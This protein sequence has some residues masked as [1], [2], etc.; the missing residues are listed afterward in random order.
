MY[1]LRTAPCFL[2]ERLEVYD[3]TLPSIVS[4]VTNTLLHK[5]D[6]AWLQ[7]TLPV[8]L[9]SLGAQSAMQVAPSA[10]LAP[11]ITIS[12]LVES[13]LPVDLH[14]TPSP[15]VDVALTRWSKGHNSNPPTGTGA[16]QEKNWDQPVAVASAE[17]LL[18]KA[19]HDMAR[20]RLLATMAQGSGAWLQA[21]PITSLGLKMDDNTLRI[22]VGLR[23]STAICASH[24]CHH[25]G[26]E[27]DCLGTHG[28][29][30]KYSE[31]RHHRHAAMTDIIQQALS[32]AKIP[33]RLESLCL[34]RS[35]GKHPDGMSIVP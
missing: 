33:S 18:N 28:L 34:S 13:I 23:L 32:T 26:A 11:T 16:S 24:P 2:S 8:K 21:L 1:L 14:S 31:G 7:A 6:H 19:P 12:V 25:C 35:D 9:G 30:C 10:F 15:F 27:V 17:S 3:T 29:S 20:A 4:N 5:E 22:S